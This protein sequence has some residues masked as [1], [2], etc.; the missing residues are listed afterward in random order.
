LL[1]DSVEKGQLPTVVERRTLVGQLTPDTLLHTDDLLAW[2]E[3]RGI[4]LGDYF[5][6]YVDGEHKIVEAAIDA[7]AAARLRFTNPD[8]ETPTEKDMPTR[9]LEI[10]AEN[11]RLRAKHVPKAEPPLL[12][13]ERNTLLAIIG[14]LAKKLGYP[15]SMPRK[16]GDLIADAAADEGFRTLSAGAIAKHIKAAAEAMQA[17][18]A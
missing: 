8:L 7:T 14:L 10:L 15:L 11:Q 6:E 17:R 12:T 9:F 2:C 13:K 4:E 1:I 16:C 3:T 18:K 5:N